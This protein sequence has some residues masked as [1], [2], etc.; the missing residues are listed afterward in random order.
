MNGDDLMD[1]D[2]SHIDEEFKKL[3]RETVANLN[4]SEPAR[5]VPSF[6]ECKYCKVPAHFCTE[7]V[8]EDAPEDLEEHDLF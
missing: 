3:F 6:R 4:S 8:K 5:K 1:I 2:P 7:R